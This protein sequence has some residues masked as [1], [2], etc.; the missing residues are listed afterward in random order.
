MSAAE[1]QPIP[2]VDPAPPAPFANIEQSALI[3]ALALRS[4][5]KLIV[6][7]LIETASTGALLRELS[8]RDDE[9][10][11]EEWIAEN[12]PDQLQ[13]AATSELVEEVLDR[14]DGLALDVIDALSAWRDG[15]ATAALPPEPDA[16]AIAPEFADGRLALS[17]SYLVRA[18][19]I[20]DLIVERRNTIPILSCA[21]IE[22]GGGMLRVRATDLDQEIAVDFLAPKLEVGSLRICVAAQPVLRLLRKLDP[23]MPVTLWQADGAVCVKWT[24]G[25]ATFPAHKA[26]EFPEFPFVVESAIDFG[27]T[28]AFVSTLDL[29]R[30]CISTEETR[31]YLNG[32]GLI[33][34]NSQAYA[35]A[36]D[37][38]RLIA[39]PLPINPAFAELKSILP[40]RTVDLVRRV[41]RGVEFKACGDRGRMMFTSFGV[42]V[43]CKMIDGDYPDWGRVASL[44]AE[45]K[46]TICV[47]RSALL[48]A[49]DRASTVS[50]GRSR[51]VRLRA[52]DGVLK[53]A[54]RNE[55]VGNA[56]ACAGAASGDLC[57][58]ADL[59]LNGDYLITALNQVEGE[60][61]IL[62]GNTPGD[63]VQIENTT[64]S[65]PI[66]IVMPLRV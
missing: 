50:P 59:G 61:V 36:T 9:H 41:F 6:D 56:D 19:A 55:D 40:R 22:A 46:K 20:C 27:D 34:R 8:D 2:G 15:H 11:V 54:A 5:V 21:S 43:R 57:A 1:T 13:N 48:L 3:D 42:T 7:M 66:V 10:A 17:A 53:V 23:D 32:V 63:P 18:L 24:G 58:D 35:V 44:A 12:A 45:A 65:G 28:S 25:E 26:D 38:H 29:V 47:D 60:T 62:R 49:V 30:P 51:S 4:D 52:K 39:Q 64:G 37:G 16:D 14:G 33:S 31:Y